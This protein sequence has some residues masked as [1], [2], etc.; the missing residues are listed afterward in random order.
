[1]D[2]TMTTYEYYRQQA[3]EAIHWVHTHL[4]Q[5]LA[6]LAIVLE[7]HDQG[8]IFL[9]HVSG[10]I[11]GIVISIAI[12]KFV[13]YYRLKKQMKYFEDIEDDISK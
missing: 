8:E 10:A 6:L 4:A 13:I 5:V 7:L 3:L 11:L 1:M 9:A 12:I 2:T